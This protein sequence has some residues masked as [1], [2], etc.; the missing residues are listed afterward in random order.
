MTKDGSVIQKTLK[1]AT[2]KEM[3][4]RTRLGKMWNRVLRI[5]GCAGGMLSKTS[6]I[7]NFAKDCR[8]TDSVAIATN[9]NAII[10]QCD[11]V[12]N[13]ANY[14]REEALKLRDEIR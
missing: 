4:N 6:M 9:C 14:L 12:I 13:H 8:D 2:V 11:E 7:Y 3:V 10:R 5:S 1:V